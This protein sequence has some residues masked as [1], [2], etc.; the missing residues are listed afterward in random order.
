MSND[1]TKGFASGSIT[2]KFE[3]TEVPTDITAKFEITDV[4]TG[5]SSEKQPLEDQKNVRRQETGTIR[6]ALD[7]EEEGRPWGPMGPPELH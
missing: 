3:I 2:A 5:V 1:N 4:P 7:D 6:K